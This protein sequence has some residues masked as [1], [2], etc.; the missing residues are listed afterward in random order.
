LDK[1]KTGYVSIDSP[2]ERKE[3]KGR[4]N[5]SQEGFINIDLN[6][7]LF[8]IKILI[9]KCHI[10]QEMYREEQR[11]QVM[12]LYDNTD[13]QIDHVQITKNRRALYKPSSGFQMQ[14]ILNLQIFISYLQSL[15]Q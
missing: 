5:L 9:Q 6:F 2:S 15:K 4:D 7:R 14:R 13:Q 10:I 11:V 1:R 12:S 3:Q 8:A